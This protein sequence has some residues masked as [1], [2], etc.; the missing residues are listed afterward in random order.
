MVISYPEPGEPWHL[1]ELPMDACPHLRLVFGHPALL[2][3]IQALK[4][5]LRKA[6]RQVKYDSYQTFRDGTDLEP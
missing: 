6:V 1:V 4:Q 2:G 5:V 3:W